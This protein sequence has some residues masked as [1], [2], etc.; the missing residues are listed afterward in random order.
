M[1]GAPAQ[2]GV[3]IQLIPYQLQ[4][5]RSVTARGDFRSGHTLS[6][7]SAV[8]S[9]ATPLSFARALRLSSLRNFHSGRE[10]DKEPASAFFNSVKEGSGVAGL[11]LEGSGSGWNIEI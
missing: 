4:K 7:K 6:K 11:G 8:S 9:A 3:L 1:N 10:S 2:V 5:S